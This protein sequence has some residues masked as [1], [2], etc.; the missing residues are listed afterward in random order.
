VRPSRRR[1]PRA[2]TGRGATPHRHAEG[3]RSTS[4][5]PSST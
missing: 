5:V 4:A 2:T 1:T 3:A